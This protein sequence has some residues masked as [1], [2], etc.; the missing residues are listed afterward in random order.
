[1]TTTTTSGRSIS[2]ETWIAHRRWNSRCRVLWL[3]LWSHRGVIGA[4]TWD[5]SCERVKE[6]R[7]A[8]A[9]GGAVTG[10]R[11][12]LPH[13]AEEDAE[14]GLLPPRVLAD[15][16]YA[17]EHHGDVDRE[18]GEEVHRSPGVGTTTTTTTTGVFYCKL[19][20]QVENSTRSCIR[21]TI[22]FPCVFKHGDG[23]L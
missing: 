11:A 17:R 9:G 13:G 7:G 18:Q 22:R 1:M 15:Q 2:G 8:S 19:H 16:G 4:T 3:N 20:V 21:V 12:Y 5:E 14:R 10:R 6:R 23:K